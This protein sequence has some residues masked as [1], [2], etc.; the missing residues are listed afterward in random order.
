MG[1]GP[2]AVTAM[3]AAG[4]DA[5]SAACAPSA[6]SAPSACY[7]PRH[8]Q[9]PIGIDAGPAAGQTL[10]NSK[11]TANQVF[12]S[13]SSVEL[14]LLP[15]DVVT[16]THDSGTSSSVH[17]RWVYG[18]KNDSK[19]QRG[20]FPLTHV[21]LGFDGAAACAP[22]AAYEPSACYAPSQRSVDLN[23]LAEQLRG[24]LRTVLRIQDAELASSAA[25]AQAAARPPQAEQPAIFFCIPAE[26]RSAVHTP[27]RIPL[28][29]PTATGAFP[30]ALAAAPAASGPGPTSANSVAPPRLTASR[31]YLAPAESLV[32]RRPGPRVNT[33]PRPNPWCLVAQDREAMTLCTQC[34]Q[35]IQESCKYCTECGYPTPPTWN[36]RR[37][38]GRRLGFLVQDRWGLDYCVPCGKY[39]SELHLLSDKHAAKVALPKPDRECGKADVEDELCFDP[40]YAR[41][42]ESWRACARR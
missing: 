3:P 9:V 23:A 33:S 2:A 18:F 4:S 25:P 30:A 5:P 26:G 21:Q 29:N 17:D 14:E 32:P 39:A 20:W 13:E 37:R 12:S 1:T 24:C 11:W 6:A 8:C 7:A 19:Q 40:P 28:E 15:G 35:E 22:S 38:H 34:R 10:Q 41:T 36:A 27:R 42:N 16:I 31:E